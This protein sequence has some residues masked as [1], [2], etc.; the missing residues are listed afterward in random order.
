M[1]AAAAPA[2]AP[3]AKMAAHAPR[4]AEAPTLQYESDEARIQRIQARLDHL[5]WVRQREVASE[6]ELLPAAAGRG[7]ASRRLPTWQA[8]SAPGAAAAPPRPKSARPITCIRMS[9][10]MT[11][12]RFNAGRGPEWSGDI[13]VRSGQ[14]SASSR[15][16]PFTDIRIRHW[17]VAA[18]APASAAPAAATAPAPASAPTIWGP[19][20][21]AA[22]LAEEEAGE[23]FS[24]A[25][26]APA[27]AAAPAEASASTAEAAWAPIDVWANAA[28]SAIVD[29][30][31]PHWDSMDEED[32]MD[33][34]E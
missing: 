15:P 6:A 9:P 1:E 31:D 27:A 7:D 26:G 4:A 34:M 21:A 18:S 12:I 2:A 13:R 11:S 24:V 14:V 32:P 29:V 30:W 3:V 22:A 20:D 5:V 19:R 17:N 23:V 25:A 8:A 16:S 10:G 28:S 33:S